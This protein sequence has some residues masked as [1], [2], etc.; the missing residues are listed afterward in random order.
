[1]SAERYEITDEGR[2]VRV[3]FAN[4][5]CTLFGKEPDGLHPLVIG[6]IRQQARDI[7]ELETDVSGL[8]SSEAAFK[9]DC[10]RLLADLAAAVA[11][12][13][14]KE[15]RLLALYMAYCAVTTERDTLRARL[16]AIDGA[17]TVA[18][19]ETQLQVDP[20]A[21][22]PIGT[23]LYAV[24][25]APVAE[26]REVVVTDEIARKVFNGWI[27][28][29]WRLNEGQDTKY[30]HAMINVVRAELGPALCGKEY[31]H[32]TDK[33]RAALAKASDQ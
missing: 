12:R 15:G 22:L 21:Q 1:M 14:K 2:T 31:D 16:A 27:D 29:R 19:V 17:P 30:G 20:G 32:V 28:A 23:K 33:A 7:S 10:D 9:N 26:M 24:P 4:K 18:M 6:A 8:R 5:S 25:P 13:D 3:S 11:E